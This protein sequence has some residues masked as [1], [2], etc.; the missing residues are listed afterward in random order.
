MFMP[1]GG[2]QCALC[3]GQHVVL[4]GVTPMQMNMSCLLHS[5][6]L[7]DL[8]HIGTIGNDPVFIAASS[9]KPLHGKFHARLQSPHE[10][11]LVI[12]IFLV[13]LKMFAHAPEVDSC[14]QLSCSCPVGYA[15]RRWRAAMCM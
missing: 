9:L 8:Y 3:Q 7:L 10:F 6:S 5:L 4:D 1:K 15:R 12:F 14:G 2:L 13:G 11:A